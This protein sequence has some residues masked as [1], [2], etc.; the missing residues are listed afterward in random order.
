MNGYR[1]NVEQLIRKTYIYIALL[2]FPEWTPMAK[3]IDYFIS[4]NNSS[5]IKGFLEFSP[6]STSN[7]PSHRSRINDISLLSKEIYFDK[8]M[9]LATRNN[10][11][12]M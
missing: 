2:F 5:E 6:I 12:K 7:L 9:A 1:K 4:G 10:S 11:L 3:E 8:F